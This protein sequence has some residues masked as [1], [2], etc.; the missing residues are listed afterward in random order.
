MANHFLER[1]FTEAEIEYCQKHK[2]SGQNFAG[3]WA[4]KEAIM[5]SL[6][7]GFV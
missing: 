3:R 4:A 1:T 6:G 2:H 5:K 7:T